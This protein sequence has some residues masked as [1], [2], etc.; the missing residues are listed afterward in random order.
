MNTAYAYAAVIFGNSSLYQNHSHL[1]W[2]FS[3]GDPP[4]HFRFI[5]K[6]WNF[7]LKGGRGGGAGMVF[8]NPKK[9]FV[10]I[11]QD[12]ICLGPVQNYNE[13]HKRVVCLLL[14]ILFCLLSHALLKFNGADGP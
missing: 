11:F 4:P 12:I 1:H 13:T 2:H 3:L 9:H 6:G 8:C 5:E 14:H 7:V 10:S